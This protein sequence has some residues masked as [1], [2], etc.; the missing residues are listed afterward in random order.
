M[1]TRIEDFALEWTGEAELTASVLDLLTDASLGQEVI[2]GR[3]T[4]WKDGTLFESVVIN[5]E[6]WL[7]GSSLRYSIMH[8]SHHRGQ[9]TVLMRQAGLQLPNV[10][11]PTYE[12]WIEEGVTPLA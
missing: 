2:E 1:F 5:K 8:Q 7:N 10:Y 11:G 4:Q 12:T 9:L 6:A 3:R